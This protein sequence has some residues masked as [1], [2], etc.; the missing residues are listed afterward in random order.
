MISVTILTK[1]SER[2]IRDVLEAL[3]SF[4]E[5]I[6]GD[7]GSDDETIQIASTFSNVKIVQF[8]FMGF[9]PSHNRLSSYTKNEWVLSI[10][11]DE[12][13]HESLVKEI[14]ALKLDKKCLYSFSRHN[15]YRGIW[16]KTCHW[17]PDRVIRLYNKGKTQFSNRLVHEMIETDGMDVIPLKGFVKHIPFDQPENFIRKLQSYSTLWAEQNPNKGSYTKASLHGLWAFFRSY[18][19]KRGFLQGGV[20]LEI[21]LYN[22]L[23]S[24]YKYIKAI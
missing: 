14:H 24:F 9:G 23:S 13:M 21:S 8:P 20:G 17:Y 11:S 22:G 16:I 5:V 7:T 3:I 10:D 4:D 1:N 12:I 2:Y 6:I 18:I 15:Y 19:L